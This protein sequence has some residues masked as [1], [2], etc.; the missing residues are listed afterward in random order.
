MLNVYFCCKLYFAVLFKLFFD[1]LIQISRQIL[2]FPLI[3]SKILFLL[4]SVLHVSHEKNSNH[5]FTTRAF[6]LKYRTCNWFSRVFFA[7]QI[8][9][10]APMYFF[11]NIIVKCL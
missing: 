5:L 8:K 4:E 11:E 6:F 10:I 1:G 3:F 9:T 2:G 7:R